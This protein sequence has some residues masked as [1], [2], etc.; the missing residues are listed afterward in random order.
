M[1]CIACSAYQQSAQLSCQEILVWRKVPSY[2]FGR[3]CYKA[4][5]KRLESIGERLVVCKDAPNIAKRA[6]DLG[7]D[8]KPIVSLLRQIQ[9]G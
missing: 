9:S 7:P 2:L 6:N 5:C 1:A 3:C 8:T 4:Q